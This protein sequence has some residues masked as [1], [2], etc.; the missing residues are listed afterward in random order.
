[1]NKQIYAQFADL[2]ESSSNIIDRKAGADR[3]GSK[4]EVCRCGLKVDG[5]SKMAGIGHG[6]GASFLYFFNP[7]Q[8]GRENGNWEFK[9]G[10]RH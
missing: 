1:M 8:P 4:D 9:A 5:I 6:K 3:C 7:A 2:D 10:I